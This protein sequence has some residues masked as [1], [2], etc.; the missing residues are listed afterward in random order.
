ME[1]F[2]SFYILSKIN[3][4]IKKKMY[5]NLYVGNSKL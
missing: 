1:V 4:K 3:F 5:S 2:K